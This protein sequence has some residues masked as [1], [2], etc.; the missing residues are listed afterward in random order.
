MDNLSAHKDKR[1]REMIE[2]AGCDLLYLPAYS[3]DLNPIEK[4]WSKVK[5]YLRR[6]SAKTLDALIQ[7]I[8]AALRSVGDDECANYFK[9][10]GYSN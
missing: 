9:A 10:C 5:T 6:V 8:V 3:P 7:A 2:A 4:L 1:V